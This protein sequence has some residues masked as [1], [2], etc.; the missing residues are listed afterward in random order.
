MET[1]SAWKSP[2]F[3]VWERVNASAKSVDSC[4][5][6]Q[7]AQAVMDR[8]FLLWLD[9]MHVKVRAYVMN[10]SIHGF[11]GSIIIGSLDKYLE[12]QNWI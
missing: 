4:Q 12:S 9:L 7:S 10:Q 5:P 3:V 8:N 6:A 1:L 11:Y 2:K